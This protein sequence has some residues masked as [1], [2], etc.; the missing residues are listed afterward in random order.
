MFWNLDYLKFQ[1]LV[2]H[3]STKHIE[4][5]EKNDFSQESMLYVIKTHSSQININ[6]TIYLPT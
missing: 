3:L 1:L 5:S 6:Q 4:N 2:F